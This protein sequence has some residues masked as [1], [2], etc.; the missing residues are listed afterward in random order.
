MILQEVTSKPIDRIAIGQTRKFSIK[1]SAKAFRILSS[2]IYPDIVAAPIRELATNAIDSHKDAGV[3]EQFLVHLPNE[4]EPYFSIRDYGTGISDENI[5]K[6]YCTYFESTRTGSNEYTGGFGLGSK[7]PFCYS[8]TFSVTSYHGGRK[9]V[10]TAFL[11]DGEPNI[12]KFA[13]EPSDEK[14]GLEVSFSVKREDIHKFV[15]T[16][17]TVYSRFVDKPKVIGAANF[18]LIEHKYVIKGENWSIRETSSTYRYGNIGSHIIMGNIGYPIDTY[19]V[20]K[21]DTHISL[22]NCGIEL[23]FGVGELQPT[24]SREHLQYDQESIDKISNRLGETCAELIEIFQKDIDKASTLFDARILYGKLLGNESP[25]GCQLKTIFKSVTHKYKNVEVSDVVPVSK[26]MKDCVNSKNYNTNVLNWFAEEFT[27]KQN[28]KNKTSLKSQHIFDFSVSQNIEFFVNDL[29]KGHE[30]RIR[31][32]LISNQSIQKSIFLIDPIIYA[33]T[34]LLDGIFE[35]IGVDKSCIK[36]TSSLDKIIP[37]K[38]SAFVKV[39]SDIMPV[40]KDNNGYNHRVSYNWSDDTIDIHN[41][42]NYYIPIVGYSMGET[43]TSQIAQKLIVAVKDID[44]KDVKLIR[45]RPANKKLEKLNNW[46]NFIDYAKKLIV[47][48]IE[49]KKLSKS[50]ANSTVYKSFL[51]ECFPEMFIKSSDISKDSYF[52]NYFKNIEL[53]ESD[54][55]KVSNMGWI[56]GIEILKNVGIEINE[57][58]PTVNLHKIREDMIKSYPLIDYITN[59]RESWRLK[60]PNGLKPALVSYMNSQ[61]SV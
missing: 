5:N 56:Y 28:R 61:K 23:N 17:R 30:S 38:R 35:L 32:Y 16:A 11:E 13:D 42:T 43:L 29:P 3:K 7:T 47:D 57:S 55:L 18:N 6:V 33:N 25:Y 44:G 60:N 36:N 48:H 37:K 24:V 19:K 1:S 54:N 53:M 58:T 8:D 52:F 15:D 34:K 9:M 14:S 21:K 39:A 26:F 2:T 49:K 27:I 10:F 20:G 46:V 50:I 45:L 31:Q 51:S 41:G 59:Q 12:A 22:L 40:F 4:F